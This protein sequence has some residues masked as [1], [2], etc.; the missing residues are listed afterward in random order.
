MLSLQSL[1]RLIPWPGARPVL[2]EGELRCPPLV[3][4]LPG[5]S[6]EAGCTVKPSWS[7]VIAQGEPRANYILDF[8]SSFVGWWVY[9]YKIS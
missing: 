9:P 3:S 7:S 5:V 2:E 8:F 1:F 6:S 4:E